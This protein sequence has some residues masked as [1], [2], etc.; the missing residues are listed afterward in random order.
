MPQSSPSA[1]PVLK[2]LA[3]RVWRGHAERRAGKR[4]QDAPVICSV[5]TP[6]GAEGVGLVN[7]SARGA[8]LVLRGPAEAG[9]LLRLHLSNLQYLHAQTVTLRVANCKAG[10][11]GLW[12]VG[13]PFVEPLSPQALG[14]LL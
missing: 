4:Y 8:C 1:W 14:A 3:R 5:L 7:L 12:I 2:R 10:A 13:G 6:A 9:A 11:N